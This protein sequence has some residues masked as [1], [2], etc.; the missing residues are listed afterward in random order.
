MVG[1]RDCREEEAGNPL[2]SFQLHPND[3]YQPQTRINAGQSKNAFEISAH[4]D[5][6]GFPSQIGMKL[7]GQPCSIFG[8]HCQDF[9][10]FSG[11][12]LPEQLRRELRVA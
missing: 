2:P 10:R 4:R 3:H 11:A 1:W 12:M 6:N 8:Q 9:L 7:L 5:G